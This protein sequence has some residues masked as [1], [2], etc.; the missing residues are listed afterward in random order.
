M[1]RIGDK[2]AAEG[3]G[4]DKDGMGRR[5]V[6]AQASYEALGARP[7]LGKTQVVGGSKGMKPFWGRGFRVTLWAAAGALTLNCP[8]QAGFVDDFLDE[9]Q[10]SVNVTQAGVMQA[11]G[12]NVVTGGGFV[13]KSPRREFSPFAVTPPS[14]R[15]GCGGIDIFL[16]AFSI[17]SREEFVSFLKSVG[18][19]LPGVA[20]QVALQVMAPDLNEI[21]GRYSDLIRGYTNRYTDSCTAAYSLLEDTGAKQAIEKAVLGAKNALRSSGE[22]AD[23]SEADRQ[24]R[25]NGQKAIAK[26]PVQKDSSGNV[27]DAAELNLTW[28]II[29]GGSFKKGENQELKELMM[30]MMGTTV[31]TKTGEGQDAVLQSTHYPGVDLLPILFGEVRDGGTISR[32]K[33]DE[34]TRCLK[35]TSAS[36]TDA[37]VVDQL[38][39]AAANYRR[40]IRERNAALVSDKELMLLGA[41]TGVPLIRILNLA[42]ASRYS[43]I[44]DDLVKIYV[45]AAAYEL[46]AAAVNSLATDTHAALSGSG[47]RQASSRHVEHVKELEARIRV[48]QAGVHEREDR[49]M[50]AMQR[51]SSLVLQLEHIEKSLAVTQTHPTLAAWPSTLGETR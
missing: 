11:G 28:S 1:R 50:Q 37:S 38:Q 32:L 6:R 42:S 16:G 43:G 36:T 10:A 47:A 8:A 41:T 5:S 15:A 46:I 48:I 45:D 7:A 27:V 24:V 49:L 29:N 2:S 20:F 51:A 22:A 12:M 44:A 34:T 14:L 39:N 40:A 31:F 33:C 23:Q 21:V 25:D 35:L 26:A 17:P 19:A 13:F 3:R 9:T 4:I 18:T 30:T